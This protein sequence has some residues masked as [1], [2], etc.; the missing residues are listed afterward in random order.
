MRKKKNLEPRLA[1]CEAV[2]V[3]PHGEKI[4]WN[5]LP[6]QFVLKTTQGGGNVGV[7]ICRDKSCFDVCYAKKKMDS[8]MKQNL[9]ATS[10]EW[11]YKDVVPEIFA[12][13]YM[14]DEHGELRDYKFFCFNKN[15]RRPIMIKKNRCQRE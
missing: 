10:R 4:D 14:E 11:P 8:A 13:E 6:N 5:A 3:H 15:E 2:T 1:A 9:Y 7:I 12:E